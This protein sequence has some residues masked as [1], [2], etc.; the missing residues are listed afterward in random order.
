MIPQRGKSEIHAESNQIFFF[1]KTPNQTKGGALFM[2]Q[3]NRQKA[4]QAENELWV[5]IP[6]F[7][8]QCL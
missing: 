7:V 6:V 8:R 4:Y 3:P 1:W 2:K 5:L